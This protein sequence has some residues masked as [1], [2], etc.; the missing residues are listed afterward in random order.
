LIC[1]SV[2]K[3]NDNGGKTHLLAKKEITGKEAKMPVGL[4]LGQWEDPFGRGGKTPHRELGS[5]AQ[6]EEPENQGEWEREF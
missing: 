5:H 4:L 6:K 2:K 3:R 1:I